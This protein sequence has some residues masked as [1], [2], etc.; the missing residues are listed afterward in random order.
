MNNIIDFVRGVGIELEE[1]TINEQS[2]LPGILINN[3]K[4]YIDREKLLYPGDI[5]HEAG[6]LAVMLPEYRAKAGNNVGEDKSQDTAQSEEMMAIAWSY[7]ALVHL[8]LAP[9]VVF[10]ADGYRGA[11]PWFIERYTSGEYMALPLLQW[12]GMAYDGE[13][14][15]QHNT[16]PYPYMQKWLREAD[17]A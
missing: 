1:R 16:L 9:E 4:M 12:T 7:A 15:Q 5:L 10:H 13:R 8:G 17:V 3:G 11:S 2:F 14:A 6:H